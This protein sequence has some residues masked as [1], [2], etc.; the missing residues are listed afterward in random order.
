MTLETGENEMIVSTEHFSSELKSISCDNS[1][2][3]TFTSSETYKAAVADWNWVNFDAQRTFIM[4]VDGCSTNSSLLPWVINNAT[5]D[6]PN[7]RVQF[8]AT[9][10]TWAE[11]TA[12]YTFDWGYYDGPPKTKARSLTHPSFDD[13]W[14]ISVDQTISQ[15]LLEKTTKSGLD[16]SIACDD[17]GTHGQILI[18]GHVKA[19]RVSIHDLTKARN[20]T[21]EFTLTATPSGV[22]VD[23]NLGLSVSG[24]LG[25]GWSDIITIADIPMLGFDIEH[26]IEFGPQLL[27]QAGFQLSGIQGNAN[28]SSGIKATIPDDSSAKIDFIEKSYDVEGWKPAVTHDPITVDAEIGGTLEVFVQLGL[29]IGV[30]IFGKNLPI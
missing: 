5:Y 23:L 28:I 27:L 30:N 15:N 19:T 18:A 10:R 2:S 12:T 24:T 14:S 29:N 1:L 21:D 26:V 3:L 25:A 7:F 9:Q 4:L 17:C 13:S 20:S 16:F 8:N 6:D 22:E 11:L